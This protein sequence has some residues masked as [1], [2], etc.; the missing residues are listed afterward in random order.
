MTST[1]FYTPVRDGYT[2]EP[3]YSCIEV[4]LD[5]GA[6]R[7]RQDVL[8]QPHLVTVNWILTNTEYAKFMGFFRTGLGNATQP[9][10]LDLVSDLSIPTA[11]KCKTKGGMP[12]LTQ[13][14]GLAYY[15][16]ATLEVE[17]NPTYTGN[18]LYQEP[19]LVI[20]A[21]TN[22]FLVGPILTG[23]TIRITDAAGTHPTGPTA[24]DMQGVYSVL[25]TTGFNTLQ[26]N[27]PTSV[28]TSWTVLAGLGAP[29]QFGDVSHG[30]VTSTLTRVPT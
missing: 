5:G 30:N 28:N 23:D 8:Y 2:F 15:V 18:I 19:D 6:T 22:P 27:G 21:T 24:L 14:R 29:G 25:S 13:Q 26:L 1:L 12:K 20:F 16:T 7:K 10:L 9:F 11:H 4:Q 17:Q 3:G